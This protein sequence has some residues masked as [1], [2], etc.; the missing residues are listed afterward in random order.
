MIY[1]ATKET[2]QRYKLKIPEQFQP[3]NA[4]LVQA[5]A[6]QERGARMYEW[7]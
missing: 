3:E 2:I 4:P 6:Q 1:Y 7:G 5:V